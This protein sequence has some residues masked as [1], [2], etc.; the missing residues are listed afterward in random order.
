MV[1]HD[2]RRGRRMVVG[3]REWR[4][5]RAMDGSRDAEG[6]AIAAAVGA[7]EVTAFA[8]QL[9]ALGLFDVAASGPSALPARDLPVRPLPDYRF[10]CS[11]LGDCCRAVDSVLFTPLEAA[12]VRAAAPEVLG[13][14]HDEALGFCPDRG[15][16]PS[17]LAVA[18]R[19]G[20]CVYLDDDGRCGVYAS[21][22]HGCRTFPRW[23]V[24]VGAEIRV[25]PRVACACELEPG[26][27]PITDARRGSDLPAALWV[28]RVPETVRVGARELSGPDAVAWCD[29]IEWTGD[30]HEACVT[31]AD[32]LGARAVDWADV[33]AR[34]ERAA[35]E[36]A[37]RAD[38][39]RVRVGLA[40]LTV[41]LDREEE[42]VLP[43]D[44]ALAARS[45]AFVGG[46][47][48]DG[49]VGVAL[50]RLA[51]QLQLA[52]RFPDEARAE[53]A[54]RHPIAT[55]NAIARATGLW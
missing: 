34:L 7:D 55:V 3:E 9:E 26:D 50:R 53:P 22:P 13:A 14:G 33:R 4:V 31:Q 10:R 11:G 45:L 18:M 5:L 6:V 23:H 42:T 32:A 27:E 52:R 36:H 43:A 29:A 12:R 30:V 51:L 44:E 54:G 20:A 19:D 37:W 17:L 48:L 47:T 40:H 8:A 24:D 25:A 39:D 35:R 46:L 28:E 41:A 38:T 2:T 15:L 21:R 49:D 16:D 1:L